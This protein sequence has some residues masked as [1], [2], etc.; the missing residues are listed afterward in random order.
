MSISVPCRS[1]FDLE[2][3]DLGIFSRVFLGNSTITVVRFNAKSTLNTNHDQQQTEGSSLN[4]NLG[5]QQEEGIHSQYKSRPTVAATIH[6]Q[7]QPRPTVEATIHGQYQPRPKV[8][9]TIHGQYQPRPT[10]AGTIHGQYQPGPTAGAGIRE[11]SHCRTYNRP[12]FLVK[13]STTSP[14][15]HCRAYIMFQYQ[16]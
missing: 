10:V 15:I 16:L 1:R 7:Y 4:V 2:F 5:P 12:G 11:K 9:A 3:R 8:A 14:E 6:D 13:I